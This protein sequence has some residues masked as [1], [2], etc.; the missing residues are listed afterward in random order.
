[1]E[2]GDGS[3]WGDDEVRRYFVV[4]VEGVA[5]A[6]A[7]LMKDNAVD[8]IRTTGC[9]LIALVGV[10]A[11]SSQGEAAFIYSVEDDGL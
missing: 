2:L 6:E 8:P 4:F 11:F 7:H 1:M 9:A 3:V 10:F 5:A